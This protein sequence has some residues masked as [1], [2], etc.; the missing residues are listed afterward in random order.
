MLRSAMPNV[1]DT[2]LAEAYPH[3]VTVPTWT[4]RTVAETLLGASRPS[5]SSFAVTADAPDG[6]VRLWL[7][8][9]SKD[10][11]RSVLVDLATK[12][13]EVARIVQE[14]SPAEGE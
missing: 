7:S 4:A 6:Q 11:L 14:N 3:M 2:G 8:E 1:Y 13:G 12:L 10:Y 5:V 9:V